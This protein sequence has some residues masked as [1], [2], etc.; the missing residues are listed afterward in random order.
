MIPGLLTLLLLLQASAQNPK[1]SVE[2]M[3]IRADTGEGIA[4]AQ[5][6]L[7]GS[8]QADVITVSS[9]RE[10]R[11]ALRDLTPGTYR[12]FGTRNGYARTE[13]GQRAVNGKGADAGG[14]GIDSNSGEHA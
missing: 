12:L 10:G 11:F 13:Y 7:S 9:D 14:V 2:G 4:G 3:V 8:N 5:I 1:A 6:T